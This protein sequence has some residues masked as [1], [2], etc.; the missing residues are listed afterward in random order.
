[1]VEYLCPMAIC[2]SIKR[3]YCPSCSC[4]RSHYHVHSGADGSII[5]NCISTWFRAR[6]ATTAGAAGTT[7]INIVHTPVTVF[8]ATKNKDNILKLLL[9]PSHFRSR[10]Q[11]PNYIVKPQPCCHRRGSVTKNKGGIF[12]ALDRRITCRPVFTLALDE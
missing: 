5:H 6:L 11:I 8:V 2:V 9:V 7:G 10:T 4:R 1:M 12:D 3:S